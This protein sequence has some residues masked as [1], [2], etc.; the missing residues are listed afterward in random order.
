MGTKD[1]ASP[2][3]G[4][5]IR[6]DGCFGGR[7]CRTMTLNMPEAEMALLEEMARRNMINKTAMIKRALRL[8]TSAYFPRLE[9]F[10]LR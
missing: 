9:V 5:V 10:L 6:H 2:V 1:E 7:R 8:L 3:E 4:V